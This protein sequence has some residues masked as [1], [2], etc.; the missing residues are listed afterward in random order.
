MKR[1]LVFGFS[2]FDRFPRN[3]SRDIVN[4][5]TSQKMRGIKIDTV[6]FKVSYASVEKMI[7]RWLNKER[8]DAVI[9]IGLAR[10]SSV[11]RLEKQALNLIRSQIAD[12]DGERPRRR[13]IVRGAPERYRS[14][15][16]LTRLCYTLRNQNI[17]AA[18]SHDAGGYVCNAAYYRVLHSVRSSRSRTA[19]LF[20]HIPLSHEIAVRTSA[21]EPSLPL[22]TLHKAAG[23]VV[24][25]VAGI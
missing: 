5:L 3:P 6:V 19:C 20:V 1:I 10:G 23:T 14:R 25:Y 24:K 18:L 7:P 21:E 22:A 2:G 17:P 8:Y 4:A 13:K 11:I 9:G 12:I 16:N 15:L